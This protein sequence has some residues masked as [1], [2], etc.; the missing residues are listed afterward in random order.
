[1][2]TCPDTGA[3]VGHFGLIHRG[4]FHGFD[5]SINRLSLFEVIGH[6]IL[7]FQFVNVVRFNLN[8]LFWLIN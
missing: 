6:K 2:W 8:V 4:E 5:H 7:N 1:M 3:A